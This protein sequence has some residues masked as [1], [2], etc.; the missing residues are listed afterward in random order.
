MFVFFALENKTGHLTLWLN[1]LSADLILC[2]AKLLTCWRQSK[3][4]R[5]RVIN[6]IL[7]HQKRQL[8]NSDWGTAGLVLFVV[9]EFSIL[10][11]RGAPRL[12]HQEHNS[13]HLYCFIFH[14]SFSVCWYCLFI[15]Y[16]LYVCPH[17]DAK[18]FLISL[19]PG[20]SSFFFF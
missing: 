20:F 1:I 16:L 10:L 14:K 11:S 8:P 18:F 3:F 5:I 2:G 13:K 12:C 4:P 19:P 7:L 6:C 15:K 17:I 9:F